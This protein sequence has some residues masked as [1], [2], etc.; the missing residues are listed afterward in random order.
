MVSVW[1]LPYRTTQARTGCSAH[2]PYKMRKGL[3]FVFV[4]VLIGPVQGAAVEL[5]LG[6]GWDRSSAGG[7]GL[8]TWTCCS[9]LLF[10]RGCSGIL[11][12]GPLR[13]G[14]QIGFQAKTVYLLREVSCS[15][16]NSC[17]VRLS[18]LDH[19]GR[20]RIHLDLGACSG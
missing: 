19:G 14:Q 8:P 2:R 10:F 13:P 3:T 15:N 1:G 7:G 17:S 5:S 16:S 9:S 11:S 18:C 6:C 20:N 12:L 4:A